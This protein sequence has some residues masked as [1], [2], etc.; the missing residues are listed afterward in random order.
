MSKFHVHINALCVSESV[1]CMLLNEFG[2]YEQFFICSSSN[3]HFSRKF[4]DSNGLKRFFDEVC[5]FLLQSKKFCGYIECEYVWLTR[6]FEDSPFNHEI[7][8]PFL[9]KLSDY[10][11]KKYLHSDEIHVACLDSS[12]SEPLFSTLERIGF[13]SAHIKKEDIM[14]RV[15][16]AQLPPLSSQRLYIILE[17][18]IQEFGGIINCSIKLEKTF[19]YWLSGEKVSFPE[20]VTDIVTYSRFH[21]G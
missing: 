9:L 15:F 12:I 21:F 2:F 19:K 7:E 20:I 6:H 11:Y 4:N 18:Y 16:T 1:K 8:I 17:S 5:C 3:Y 10:K 14:Y 13:Y